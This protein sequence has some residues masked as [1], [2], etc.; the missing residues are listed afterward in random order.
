MR[1]TSVYKWEEALESGY[2]TYEKCFDNWNDP[3]AAEILKNGN[4]TI[5]QMCEEYK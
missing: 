4:M 3:Y 1:L 5:E 2:G